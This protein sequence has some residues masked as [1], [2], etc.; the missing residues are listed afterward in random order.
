[1]DD[2]VKLVVL[3][4]G[5]KAVFKA[6]EY[7][8]AEVAAYKGNRAVGQ[9]LVPPTVLRTIDGEEGSL[10]FFVE[11][12]LDPLRSNNRS[13][14]FK[15]LHPKMV[16]DMHIFYFVF[17]QWDIHEGN[18][19]ITESNGNYYLALIDNAGI[20]HRQQVRYGEFP[21]VGKGIINEKAVTDM[22][23]TFPFDKP[24][25][26][27]AS[28]YDRLLALFSPF[29]EDWHIR[30]MQDPR[31]QIVYCLWNHGLYVQIYADSGLKPTHTDIYYS[32]TLE[33]YQKLDRSI[34]R[35]VWSEGLSVEPERYEELI[36][37][38]LERRDQLILAAQELGTIIKD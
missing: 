23:P 14:F 12:S 1:M 31:E 21:F 29:L 3:E 18:Q 32:S 8:Y 16:S 28:S 7:R 22:G 35:K 5:L 15:K 24:K 38:I 36:D 19:I 6:G 25:R 11:S 34:L 10:Q 4:S 20:K 27:S 13:S 30:A 17:G 33:A 26:V 2:Y 37:L 9:R